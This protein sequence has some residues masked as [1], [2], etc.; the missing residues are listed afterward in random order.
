MLSFRN[1]KYKDEDFKVPDVLK[2]TE[3]ISQRTG[4]RSTKRQKITETSASTKPWNQGSRWNLVTLIQNLQEPISGNI[5]YHIRVLNE[6][7]YLPVY[8]L[9]LTALL[10]PLTSIPEF[11]QVEAI[12]K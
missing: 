6:T 2:C 1:I 4:H 11:R 5:T 12:T 8:T 10:S 3:I 7:A 9:Y